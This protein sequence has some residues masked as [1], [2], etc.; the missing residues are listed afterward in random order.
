MWDLY[1]LL[2]GFSWTYEFRVVILKTYLRFLL[3]YIRIS[4]NWSLFIMPK[5]ILIIKYIVECRNICKTQV[6]VKSV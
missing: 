6:V 3:V 2:M 4:I 1:I 5:C